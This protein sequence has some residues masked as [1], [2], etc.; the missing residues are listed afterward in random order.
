MKLM[1]I[2]NL[3]RNTILVKNQSIKIFRKLQ[4]LLKFLYFRKGRKKIK[5][6]NFVALNLFNN[7]NKSWGVI[8]CNTS[9]N[10]HVSSG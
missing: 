9:K 5:L 2:Y 6:S 8:F 10:E 3:N 1:T 7:F 4:L